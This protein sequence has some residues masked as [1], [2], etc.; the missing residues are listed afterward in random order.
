MLNVWFEIFI[1]TTCEDYSLLGY[2]G[3]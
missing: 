3:F 1:A 2:Y